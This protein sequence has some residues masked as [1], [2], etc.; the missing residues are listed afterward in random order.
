ML[1]VLL[2]LSKQLTPPLPLPVE[3]R[4]ED[5]AILPVEGRGSM[6]KT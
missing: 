4:G 3:G 1:G 5:P 2:V 6:R